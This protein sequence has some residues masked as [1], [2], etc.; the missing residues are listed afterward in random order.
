[1]GNREITAADF[2]QEVEWRKQ[3]ERPLP[4]KEILLGE[5]ISR[6][7]ALQKAKALGLEKDRD[8]Q[9]TYEDILTSKLRERELVSRVSA[10]KVSPEEVRAD[11]QKDLQRYTQPA[12]ARLALIYIKTD[13][14]MS[15]EKIAEQATRMGE[16]LALAK[17]LPENVK[18]FDRVAVDFSEDQSSRYKGGDVGW[19]DEGE[20]RYRW[21]NEVVQAGFALKTG[22]VSSVIK[23]SDGFYLIKKTDA[24]D[25]AVASFEQ[26]QG[27]I[28]HQ[29][30]A[31]KR[32]ETEKDFA[33]ELQSFAPVQTNEQAL[34]GID[35]PKTTVATAPEF[36]PPALPRSQ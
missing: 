29:L 5:M 6:E 30:L 36:K 18:G 32:R 2:K 19:F 34:A 10:V 9:R 11:Y 28:Q 3:N 23:T 24:R 4:D 15:Q 25:A 20:A 1:V 13:R 14:K 33:R 31:E 21:P 17:A 35:Y 27:T 8:V 16:V 7:L 26:V 12:K 22:E